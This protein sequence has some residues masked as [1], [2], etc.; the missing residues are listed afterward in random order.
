MSTVLVG[1]RWDRADVPLPAAGPLADR[2]SVGFELG[3]EGLLVADASRDPILAEVADRVSEAR[4]MASQQARYDQRLVGT[5]LRGAAELAARS[6]AASERERRAWGAR[7]M[8]A[9]LACALHLPDT[10]L[11]RRL[12]RLTMLAHLPSLLAAAEAGDLSSWHM[13]AVLDVFA[14]VLDPEVLARADAA[15]AVR[16]QAMTAPQLRAA[17]R[18]WRARYVPRTREQRAANLAD[19]HV[20]LSPAD[21]DMVWLSALIPAAAG[22][23]I[24]ARLN[25][26]ADQVLAVPGE[27][28][29]RAQ[30]RTDELVDLLLNPDA[31]L[32][33]HGA[34][35]PPGAISDRVEASASA[36]ERG[37]IGTP[38][39][40][41]GHCATAGAQAT[42]SL[43]GWV[44]GVKADLV[45]T[46]PVL[47]LLG[48]GDEPAELEGVGPIDIETAKLLAGTATSF[49]R[50]LTH[51]HTGAVLGVGRDRYRLPA[52]LRRAVQV[53]DQTC[54]FPGCRRRAKGCDVDHSTD[55][56]FGGGSDL[57]NL[58]CLCR[59]HHRLK[60]QMRWTVA[61]GTSGALTW[62]SA[63]GRH[64]T[65]Q[66]AA[67]W[68]PPP[69]PPVAR[70]PAPPGPVPDARSGCPDEPPF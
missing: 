25:T 10:S 17:A 48:H 50:V 27:T 65:T 26:L 3:I 24:D 68:P 33:A 28:R 54:R 19:R 30:A 44:R 58:A 66:P 70:P 46:V 64:Y 51:P 37:P 18:R 11:A 40:S 22:A 16:A 61:H 1:T 9:E 38:L 20:H 6:S 59:K 23:A 8:L 5:Y 36:G 55:W 12:T 35:A 31:G 63:L 2:P 42:G 43:P 47:T 39:A 41:P 53:R 34:T 21:E 15:L 29:T 4:F 7:A 49:L 14:G 32:C 62:T 69:P 60:H 57:C 13:E 56:L 67:H 52:D 45:L